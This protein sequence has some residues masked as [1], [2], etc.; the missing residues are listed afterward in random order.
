MFLW[1]SLLTRYVTTTFVPVH[2]DGQQANS[3]LPIFK[4]FE[5]PLN[6]LAQ[7]GL[8]LS[9]AAAMVINFNLVLVWIPMCKY[10]LTKL[11][12]I[13][14]KYNNKQKVVLE[15][16]ISPDSSSGLITNQ[17]LDHARS[18]SMSLA[19]G[20]NVKASNPSMLRILVR[21]IKLIVNKINFRINHLSC[22]LK[23]RAVDSFLIAV[24]HSTT[25]HTI[26][27]TTITLASGKF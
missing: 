13:A 6:N 8:C 11:A 16:L 23:I 1:S 21:K 17:L 3:R 15:S 26:S 25:L 22:T 24:D 18:G 7:I 10:T 12:V 27:A 14:V 2:K 9:R 5:Q 20:G 4:F 19:R